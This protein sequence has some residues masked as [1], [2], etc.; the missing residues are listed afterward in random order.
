MTSELPRDTHDR[1]G[2]MDTPPEERFDRIT[3]LAQD[4][5]QVDFALVNIVGDDTVY[6]K[7]QPPGPA[8]GHSA[9]EDVFC[10][11][12]IRQD[13]VLE[14]RDAAADDRYRDRKAVTDYGMRFYAGVPLRTDDGQAVATLCLLDDTPRTLDGDQRAALQ[15]FG[16]WAQA[17][18][19]QS[20]PGPDD[21][22]PETSPETHQEDLGS[23]VHLASLA[24]PHG[25][26]SGDRS[27]WMQ[28][29][30]RVVV[31]LADVMGKGEVAG[32]FADELLRAMQERRDMDPVGALTSVESQA[33]ADRRFRDTF[34]TIFH[35][36]ID[37]RAGRLDYVDAGHGLSLVL[38]PD[39][40]DERLSSR[41]LPLGL[42]PADMPWEAGSSAVSRGDLIVS[43]SDGALDAYDSTLE[44]LRLIGEDLRRAARADRFFEELAVRVSTHAVDD[45]VTAV[46]VAIH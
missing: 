25:A 30:G 46:V 24:I 43:V 35:A 26:V 34:A 11:E 9:P 23:E 45:D 17:E 7:S 37:T 5:F 20:E 33:G 38:H 22:A 16:A 31:T 44:S 3:R 32:G 14:I 1:T 8:I 27:G 41:N 40:S 2:L 4:L 39:G 36:V 19:R 13:G 6:T 10:A 18:L 29:G 28:V 15:R 12:T 21:T 42:R